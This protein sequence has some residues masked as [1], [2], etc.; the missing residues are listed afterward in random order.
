MIDIEKQVAYWRNGALSDWEAAQVLLRR[1][2]V[3][4]GLF[5]LHLALEKALKAHVCRQTNDLAPRIHDLAKLAHLARLSL[6][7]EQL[8]VLADANPFDF[9]S[10]YG[11]AS[12]PPLSRQEAALVLR[13][14]EGVFE[15]MISQL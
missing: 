5:L 12:L 8:D 15:W 13:R 6:S 2:L 14:T 7:E 4:Q 10:L 9:E 3:R 11:D 1:Q